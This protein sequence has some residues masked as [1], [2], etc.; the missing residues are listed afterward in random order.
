MLDVAEQARVAQL[1]DAE[2]SATNLASLV[3]AAHDAVQREAWDAHAVSGRVAARLEALKRTP[4]EQREAV[5][6]EILALLDEDTFRDLATDDAVPLQ[7]RAVETVLSFGYPWA[8]RLRPED[9]ERHHASRPFGPVRRTVARVGYVVSA[10]AALATAVGV[11]R[12]LGDTWTDPLGLLLLGALGALGLISGITSLTTA[13]SA[14]AGP[15]T[16]VAR[17]VGVVAA[18][19]LC[20]PTLVL[21]TVSTFGDRY[22]F[23]GVGMATALMTGWL[24]VEVGTRRLKKPKDVLKARR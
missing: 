4:P 9:L 24:A 19:L 3:N 15:L 8:L 12:E 11:Y 21:L 1:T 2:A 23:F 20:V 14:D 22:S 17:V 13:G 10:L 18:M 7:Y 6:T 5:T 16:K